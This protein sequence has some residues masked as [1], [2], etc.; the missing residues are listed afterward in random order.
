MNLFIPHKDLLTSPTKSD[1]A[2][3]VSFGIAGEAITGS[4]QSIGWTNHP[5]TTQQCLS[6]A[7][8]L[9]NSIPVINTYVLYLHTICETTS[10][11]TMWQCWKYS[12]KTD[13]HVYTCT[14]LQA[15]IATASRALVQYNSTQILGLFG[16]SNLI[17]SYH[18]PSPSP[19][20]HTS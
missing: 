18:I 3:C 9:G 11:S 16:Q 13:W 17:F 6:A 8:F 14:S 7:V 10:L 15:G 12:V 2:V 1:R 19:S 4:L 20:R 5:Q